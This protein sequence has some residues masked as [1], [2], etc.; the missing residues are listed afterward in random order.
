MSSRSLPI[1]ARLTIWYTLVLAVLL[2]STGVFF[3][4]STS[5]VLRAQVDSALRLVA[6]QAVAGVQHIDGVPRLRDPEE[7]RTLPA[8][9]SSRGYALRLI[10][11]SGQV[12]DGAG[13]YRRLPAVPP[14][15]GLAT[16]EAGGESWRLY[17]LPLS[18]AAP[19]EDRQGEGE[20]SPLGPAAQAPGTASSTFVQVGQSMAGVQAALRQVAG[21]L[22]VGI[23]LALLLAAAGGALLADRALGPIVSITGQA[24]RIGAEVWDHG[25]RALSR[26]LD[27]SLPDDEVGRL[28][29]TFDEMLGRLEQTFR[30]E[31]QFT[32][33][34]AHE[35]RTPL[36]VLRGAIDVTLRRERTPKEYRRT[37][38]GLGREVGRLI[39]LSEDLL[40][41]A[42]TEAR[43]AG[44]P[45]GAVADA[46]EAAAGVV[47]L[48]R[49]VAEAKGITLTLVTPETAAMP[50]GEAPEGPLA[51]PLTVAADAGRLERAIYN[52]VHNA[53]KFTPDGGR[54]TVTVRER[55]RP[56]GTRGEAVAAA[57]EPPDRAEAA[58]EV[59]VA[60]T[61]CGVSPEDLPRVF[62]RFFRVDRARTR[63]SA[64]GPGATVKGGSG[65]GLTIARSIARLYGGDI[66]AASVLGRGSVFTLW[67]PRPPGR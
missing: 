1:R 15:S 42:E 52:L 46:G 35:L 9:L 5:R 14:V 31:R 12:L 22:T 54:V 61:G 50:R 64:S 63:P 33:D 27:L 4:V 65:L 43:A 44:L 19:E 18:A 20:P 23:P 2:V 55:P 49:P 34:A 58:V 29:R 56:T 60:D 39:D 21:W 13:E 40:L 38:V 25:P 26:R 17:S 32:S 6:V 47:E 24:R 41:V 10:T 48:L 36:T 37:L 57:E 7:P 53:L 16:V 59:E 28:A 45:P 8:L 51:G 11:A 30:R 66:S 3:Y 62:D 67:L